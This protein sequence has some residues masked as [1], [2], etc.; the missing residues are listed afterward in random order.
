MVS[1]VFV[2]FYVPETKGRTYPEIDELWK[3]GVPPRKWSQHKLFVV[4]DTKADG[5]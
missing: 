5:E 3:L 1:I 4:E 2:F